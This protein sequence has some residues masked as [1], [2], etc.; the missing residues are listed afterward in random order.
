[1][2][3]R[4][5]SE[6]LASE[7][8]RANP[9]SRAGQRR[10]GSNSS[11]ADANDGEGD[12]QDEVAAVLFDV[13][14]LSVVEDLLAS[15]ASLRIDVNHRVSTD[16]GNLHLFQED[17]HLHPESL[18][19]LL[20]SLARRCNSNSRHYSNFARMPVLYKDDKLCKAASVVND[21][22][23]WPGR[24]VNG[25]SDAS[26]MGAWT[27]KFQQL[28]EDYTAFAVSRSLFQFPKV[29]KE[30][31][32]GGLEGPCRDY[33]I[34][35]SFPR[36]ILSRHPSLLS[37]QSW[38]NGSASVDGL[39]RDQL[40]KFVNAAAGIG[41]SGIQ[42][43]LQSVGLSNL[44]AY[45]IQYLSDIKL[46]MQKDCDENAHLADCIRSTFVGLSD[47]D[48]KNKVFYLLN[49]RWE[50]NQIDEA[51]RLVGDVAEVVSYEYDGLVLIL[52]DGCSWSQVDEVLPSIFTFKPYRPRSELK[53]LLCARWP[54]IPEHAWSLRFSVEDVRLQC[55]TSDECTRRLL[56]G[57]T[58]A[59]P[60]SSHLPLML[61]K[62]GCILKDVFKTIPGAQNKPCI[63]TCVQHSN[64]FLWEQL[65]NGMT[66][67]QLEKAIILACSIQCG[68]DVHHTP[69]HW[70]NGT[71]T[72]RV[73]PRLGCE[74]F[75]AKFLERLDGEQ[76]LK[77]MAFKCGT[78]YN[79]HTGAFERALADHCISFTVGYDCPKQTLDALEASCGQRLR[80]ALTNIQTHE[81][82]P[83]NSTVLP[84]GIRDELDAIFASPEF[85]II[86]M[87]HDSFTKNSPNGE[88]A[89]GWWVAIYRG[90]RVI[91]AAVSVSE[92][93]FVID[94]GD[95]GNN[96]K[97]FIWNVAKH[98][99]GDYAAEIPLTLLT[100]PPPPPGSVNPTLFDLRWKRITC[101]PESERRYTMQSKWF[102]DLG[103][104][105]TTYKCRTLYS[106]D[107][108]FR[109][110]SIFHIATN[111]NLSFSSID[112]GLRHRCVGVSW[113]ISFSTDPKGEDQRRAH[114]EDIKSKDFYTIARLSGFIFAIMQVLRVWTPRPPRNMLNKMPPQV[115]DATARVLDA[116][117][118]AHAI[119][120]V[121]IQ[122]SPGEE[123]N[124][125]TQAAFMTNLK[126]YLKTKLED[127]RL[128]DEIVQAAA[129]S[130]V[131]FRLPSS[132]GRTKKTK[133][134]EGKWLFFHA[135]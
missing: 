37:I 2:P 4:P 134:L 23:A 114:D 102:K 44:P 77:Y 83:G 119:E 38:V 6:P 10:R 104:Q 125:A 127:D 88:E 50:R 47:R 124:A 94:S 28:L 39:T 87:V 123:A 100:S 90:L 51:A 68:Y 33:D 89:G 30:L 18:R 70:A 40:K 8:R 96:G 9:G 107:I 131:N 80:D 135:G 57:E 117:A 69:A 93:K 11:A 16:S 22:R 49:S 84:Q 59:L 98:A 1:L 113:P 46:A 45:C 91:A 81:A 82:L 109:V 29:L 112:G 32:R 128:K 13:V 92:P 67:L 17:H 62:H 78:L 106:T 116:V 26:K 21:G 12:R 52:R 133:N 115:L 85:E 132:G 24:L 7:S 60:L 71:L 25:M 65:T 95:D 42:Q 41:D 121:S 56:K 105:S 63:Y 86:R 43:W 79:M 72:S 58:P 35:S 31:L 54:E 76:T 103:D 55:K 118:T 75:D 122:M 48:V 53:A 19:F 36:A 64:G 74:L 110:P 66:P 129:E 97:G 126:R 5:V 27:E 14:D 61:L 108:S 15:E 3:S 101:T 130:V 34:S 99:L 73:V 111:V 20:W 120:F